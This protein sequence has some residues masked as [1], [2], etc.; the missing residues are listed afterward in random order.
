MEVLNRIVE[1]LCRRQG[2]A[3]GRH[4]IIGLG[5]P[6][7][8]HA[9]NR[10]NV[11]FLLIDQLAREHD[12]AWQRKRSL[13]AL[14]G[15]GAIG[16]HPVV[17]AKPLTYMNDSGR[18]IGAISRWYKISPVCV[19]VI[20]DDLDLPIGRIR[21]RA[22]GSSGGHRGVQSAAAALGSEGFA[23][24]RV[25]IGRPGRGDPVDYVLGDLSRDEEQVICAASD[26]VSEIVRCYLDEGIA[27]AMNAYNGRQLIPDASRLS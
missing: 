11:G 10:H 23:R 1:S 27:Q 26:W 15:E 25:G 16:G 4:L 21:L 9:R 14:L 20:H 3:N 18:S 17:L 13:H 24:F 8:E 6:G 7:G 5:N 19:L 22:G 2:S 12:I